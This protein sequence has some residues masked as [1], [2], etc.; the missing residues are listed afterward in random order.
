[1]SAIHCLLVSALEELP[2]IRNGMHYCRFL[3]YIYYPLEGFLQTV[4]L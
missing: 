2:K 4:E 1:M 3:L